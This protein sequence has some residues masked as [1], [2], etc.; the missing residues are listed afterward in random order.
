[1]KEDIDV[2][3]NV[4]IDK[5]YINKNS[6]DEK[7]IARKNMVY[8]KTHKTASSAVQVFIVLKY[9]YLNHKFIKLYLYMNCD[10]I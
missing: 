5:N 7:C 10:I 8:L 1:M 3:E 9:F 2:P 4:I 6:D